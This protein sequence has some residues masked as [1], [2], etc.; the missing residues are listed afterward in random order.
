M[1]KKLF[2]SHAS[3]DKADF[4]RPLADALLRHYEVWFDEYELVVGQ[5]LLQE[6]RN[7]L[8]N[9]DYGVVIISKNFF[10]KH[11]TQSELNGLFALEEKDKKVILPVWK[12]VTKAEVTAYSPILADRLAAHASGG[13]GF[14][15]NEIMRSI[16]FFDRGKIVQG[17]TAGISKL[18]EIL[19]KKVEV[20]R[21]ARIIG[22][23]EG[24]PIARDYAQL[25]I[26]AL[27]SQLATIIQ[28]G[29]LTNLRVD[30]P[31]SDALAVWLNAWHG[32]LCLHA[33][34]RNNVINSAREAKIDMAVIKA[35]LSA[36]GEILDRTP[37]ERSE[38]SV[39]VDSSD[40]R[41]WQ[42][43]N[44]D[45]TSEDSLVSTWLGKFA[46]TIGK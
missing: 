7:G 27:A 32:S 14:V 30:G 37:I 42:S 21:S 18:R 33:S 17:E 8:A 9:C 6:I 36:F 10:N 29:A 34:Y 39:F 11:W 26:S 43:E 41:Y 25:T 45:L 22:S 38:Y 40:K 13:V 20:E 5:S 28:E 35:K 4:A 31:K 2:V 1:K 15:V 12:D 46:D 44:G 16:D 23:P 24:I 19:G 3:E